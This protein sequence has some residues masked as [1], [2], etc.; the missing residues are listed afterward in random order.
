M[1][2]KKIE[3][4]EKK[5]DCEDFI[6]YYFNRRFCKHSFKC[7][8]AGIEY[9]TRRHYDARGLFDYRCTGYKESKCPK[10]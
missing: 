1:A 8:N 2:F 9:I 7:A 3:S 4:K 5:R 6:P 10:S